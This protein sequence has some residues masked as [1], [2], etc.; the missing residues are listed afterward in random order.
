MKT[1]CPN[2]GAPI[3]SGK[4]PYCGTILY[5]FAVLSDTDPVYLRIKVHNNILVFKALMTEASIERH[6]NTIDVTELG[7][8]VRKI[9]MRPDDV[10]ITTNFIVLAD[11]KTDYS[12]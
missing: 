11:D 5:D 10:N 1:N 9:Q 7:G 12:Y 4:C 8:Y 6:S 3:E 2:C